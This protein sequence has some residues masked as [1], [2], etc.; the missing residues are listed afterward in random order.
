MSYNSKPVF[1]NEYMKQCQYSVD[2]I[3][4]ENNDGIK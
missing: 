2:K 4:N 1:H 3:L